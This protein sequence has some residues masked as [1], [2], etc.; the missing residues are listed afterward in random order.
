MRGDGS[1]IVQITS[2]MGAFGAVPWSVAQQ[3]RSVAIESDCDLVPGANLDRNGELFLET[4]KP[5]QFPP[6]APAARKA[7]APTVQGKPPRSLL[8]PRI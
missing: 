6:A 1:S 4:W 3:G 7:A 2:C 8:A 5:A